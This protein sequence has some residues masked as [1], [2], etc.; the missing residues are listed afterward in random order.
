MINYII[1]KL[2]D[3]TE[4][5]IIVENGGIGYEIFVPLSV[6][7]RVGQI[8]NEV[9]IYTYIY[10]RED[11]LQLFGFIEKDELDLFKLLITVSGIGPKGALGILSTMSANDLRFAVI[12]E[13]SKTIARAPGIGAKTAKKLIL[14]LKDKL[15]FKDV[16]DNASGQSITGNI[17]SDSDDATRQM[18]SDAVSVLTALGYLPTDAMKAV[19][20]VESN[21]YSTVEELLK[22]SLKNISL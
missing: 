22:L 11:L 20:S 14:E 8:G 21:T 6:I 1:G 10:V 9:K 4:N 16:M 7:N 5:S 15:K 13:D 19:K 3:I 2:A 17:P 12:A 18:I